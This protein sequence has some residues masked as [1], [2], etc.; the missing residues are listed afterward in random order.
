[1]SLRKSGIPLSVETPAPPK[2]TIFSLSSIHFFS[3][4]NLSSIHEIKYYAFYYCRSLTSVTIPNSVTGIGMYAFNGCSSLTSVTIPDSVTKIRDNA[5]NDCT[6][7]TRVT[8]GNSVTGI[9]MYAFNGCSSLT[10][11]TIPDSVTLIGCGAFYDCA[12]L[13]EVYCKATTPPAIHHSTSLSVF[14]FNS[15]IKIYIPRHSYDAYMQYDSSSP[16][17]YEQTNWYVYESYIV[18]YDFE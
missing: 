10:S 5:F 16:G 1:P 9:G 2:N 15:G 7:L 17:A 12:S 8:I 6:A 18:P 11:I 3:C 13:K 4:F 14:P